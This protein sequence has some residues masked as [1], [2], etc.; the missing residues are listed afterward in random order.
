VTEVQPFLDELDQQIK[1][2]KVRARIATGKAKLQAEQEIDESERKASSA[3]DKFR[4]LE[5]ASGKAWEEM[6]VG[7]DSA[8]D[9]LR[10]SCRRAWARF[11]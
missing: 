1:D 9:E 8:I 2:L 7:L 4:E 11:K 10:I 6:K 5:S 3:K